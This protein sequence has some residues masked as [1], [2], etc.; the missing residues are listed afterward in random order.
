MHVIICRRT[1]NTALNEFWHLAERLREPCEGN[2]NLIRPCVMNIG[3]HIRVEWR[4]NDTNKLDGLR[5]DYY[6]ADDLLTLAHLEMGAAKVNG[7]ELR[8]LDDV[9]NEVVK[10]Y[11]ANP[12]VSDNNWR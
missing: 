2:I 1:F 9:F 4:P 6:L 8:S 11:R 5:P 10:A 7:K 3:P 12:P